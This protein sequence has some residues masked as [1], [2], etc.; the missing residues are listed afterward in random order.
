M[1]SS[2]QIILDFLSHYPRSSDVRMRYVSAFYENGVLDIYK[3][4]LSTEIIRSTHISWSQIFLREIDDFF[5]GSVHRNAEK[6]LLKSKPNNARPVFIFNEK[7]MGLV[8]LKWVFAKSCK[9]FRI[10]FFSVIPAKLRFFQV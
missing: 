1:N 7:A 4:L 3:D 6:N 8:K 5:I 10:H 9:Y 2:A